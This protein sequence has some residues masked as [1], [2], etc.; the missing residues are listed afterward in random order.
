MEITIDIERGE[1]TITVEVLPYFELGG[2]GIARGWECDGIVA[3]RDEYGAAIR[4]E[5]ITLTADEELRAVEAIER[6]EQRAAEAA[7]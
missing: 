1:R 4:A 7:Y 5:D 3:A 6:A 2:N